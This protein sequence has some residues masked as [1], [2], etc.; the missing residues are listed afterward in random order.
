VGR[1]F[2]CPKIN[3]RPASY[4]KIR[5]ASLTI[6]V[7]HVKETNPPEGCHPVEWILAT[8]EPIDS[9]EAILHIVDIYRNRWL[10]EEFF[11]A[12]KTGC[13]FPDRQLESLTTLKVALAFTLPIAWGLLRLRVL[14]KIAPEADACL[15][16]TMEQ[17]TV[18]RAK[19]SKKLPEHPTVEQA[20]LA[21]A[22]LGGFIAHNKVVGWR[23]L[24]RG[25]MDLLYLVEGYRLALEML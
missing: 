2:V 1:R 10:I 23:V 18:L 8:T 6:N 22:Q 19:T 15:I 4:T 7:V 20:M 12:I 17:L 3:R 21:V 11:C 13:S 24:A 5:T 16:L 9:T 14:A 25:Y